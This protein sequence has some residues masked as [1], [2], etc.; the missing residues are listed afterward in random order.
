MQTSVIIPAPI[1]APVVPE[2]RA[3]SG[4]EEELRFLRDQ[5]TSVCIT[6]S[7]LRSMYV[8][9]SIDTA[10]QQAE[11]SSAGASSDVPAVHDLPEFP[12][13][14][15]IS[16]SSFVG[17][18]PPARSCRSTRTQQKRGRRSNKRDKERAS[19]EQSQ[20]ER[21]QYDG[22]HPD[23]QHEMLIGYDD[24]M[25]QIRQLEFKVEMLE[26]EIRRLVEEAPD[27]SRPS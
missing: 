6:L 9:V 21:Q 20:G 10:Q 24:A 8:A 1:A 12:V 27:P 5:W 2:A 4:F 23:V 13:P 17:M 7:S 26:A 15:S 18:A 19:N 25:L 3:V 16:V 11:S 22:I 14:S